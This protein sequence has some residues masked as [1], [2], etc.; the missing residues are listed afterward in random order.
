MVQLQLVEINLLPEK[1]KKQK[2]IQ[3]IYTYAV[4]AGILIAAGLIGIVWIQMQKIAEVEKEIKKIDAESAALQDKIAQVKKFNEME[5]LYQKKKSILDK[6]LKEQSY[7]ARV[8]DDISEMVLPDMWLVA[9]RDVKT[10]QEGE[11]IDIEGYAMSRI[12]VADFIKKLEEK[13]NIINLTTT[14]IVE[15]VSVDNVN[16]VKFSVSF[17]YKFD[18]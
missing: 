8:F 3:M 1:L 14:E 11:Q 4:M 9:I 17:V 6:L 18:I 5:S 15:G 13:S 16:A 12:I 7:W 2:Q 10:K